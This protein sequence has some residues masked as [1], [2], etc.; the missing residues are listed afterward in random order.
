MPL[1]KAAEYGSLSARCHVIRSRL[2]ASELVEQLSASRSIGE[3]ASTL[4]TTHYGSFIED[5]SFEGVQQA[6]SEAFDYQ[7]HHITHRLKKR[8]QEIFKLFFSTKQKLIDK[9]AA[10]ATHTNPEDI[11]HEIDKNYNLLLKK[12][13]LQTT[14]SER[15]QL[16]KIVG[17]YFDLLNLYTLVK[18]RLL[19]SLSTE[20]TLTYML[21]FAEKFKLEELA[22]LCAAKN[23]QELSSTIEPTLNEKFHNYETFR[24]ALYRYHRKYL[25]SAWCG[26]PFSIAI[27]FSLLR[28][29]EIE[30]SNLRAITE[31]VAFGLEKKEIMM[32][33]VG[34]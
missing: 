26:Y 32:M 30:V 19:Y 4:S 2:I 28:L 31:G 10:K 13:M 34:D 22:G 3:L 12:S 21:P 20:E 33:T 8:H 7:Y 16:K 27:P 17:S 1:G 23:L 18:L 6:L 15:R 14:S 24:K 5:I 25:L 29:M 11:F 9:K